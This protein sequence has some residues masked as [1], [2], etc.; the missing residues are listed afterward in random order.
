MNSI[1]LP[2][3]I[4]DTNLKGDEFKMILIKNNIFNTNNNTDKT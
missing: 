1:E 2:T 4:L 3:E